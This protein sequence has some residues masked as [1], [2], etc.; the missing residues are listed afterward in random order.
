MAKNGSM[1]QASLRTSL[2]NFQVCPRFVQRTLGFN[3]CSA[4]AIG[5]IFCS[6]AEVK[7]PLGVY[8]RA[9]LYIYI[10]IRIFGR[11]EDGRGGGGVK[12]GCVCDFPL[13]DSPPIVLFPA[14][15][16]T[17]YC[18]GEGLLQSIPLERCIRPSHGHCTDQAVV[19]R[20]ETAKVFSAFPGPLRPARDQERY[21]TK[22]SAWHPLTQSRIS[23]HIV[24]APSVPCAL[25]LPAQKGALSSACQMRATISCT[26]AERRSA[27]TTW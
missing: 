13:S 24:S 23:W 2:S 14:T 15:G 5:P 19:N 12:L 10:C 25:A 20:K 26:R 27:A 11:R 4:T 17:A 6:K 9:L 16:L 18:P 22:D 1:S 7:T 3:F 8:T 21:S